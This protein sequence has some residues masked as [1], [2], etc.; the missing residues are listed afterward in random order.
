MDTVK[1]NMDLSFGH[2]SAQ[3]LT[4][5]SYWIPNH[6]VDSAW[7]SHGSF[8][9]WIVGC[10]KPDVIAELGTHNGFSY[11]AFC[12]AAQRLALPVRSFAMDSWEGDDQAGFYG[13]QVFELVS[14]V[15]EE[16]FATTSTLIRGYFDDAVDKFE[17]GS[18]DLFHIDGRHTYEDVKHDFLTWLPKLSDRAVVLFHDL[19]EREN[20]FGVWRLW[21]EISSAYPSFS[22]EH[23]HG[24]GVLG[25]GKTFPN[26]LSQLFSADDALTEKIRST[27][28]G[29]GGRIYGIYALLKAHEQLAIQL[30]DAEV[31]ISELQRS[32]V[33]RISELDAIYSSASWKVALRLRS[34]AQKVPSGVRKSIRQRF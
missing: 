23:G 30:A 5:E 2:T 20:G 33:E 9:S 13:E 22:F 24:L 3:W 12:E 29:L 11:F 4:A 27:Y 10:L 31:A 34:A 1:S 14:S 18:I 25:I 16:K 6:I 15:N 28:S 8:A 32:A 17:D 21:D 26:G 19:V 7:L